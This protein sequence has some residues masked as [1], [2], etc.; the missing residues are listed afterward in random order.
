V[1]DFYL[2]ECDNDVPKDKIQEEGSLI[3]FINSPNSE[4]P[5][6][7][8]CYR[9]IRSKKEKYRKRVKQVQIKLTKIES[10]DSEN[11]I[12][13]LGCVNPGL[14]INV[15]EEEVPI[16]EKEE[17]SKI[18]VKKTKGFADNA[19][20]VRDRNRTDPSNIPLN[21]DFEEFNIYADSLYDSKKKTKLNGRKRKK[22]RASKSQHGLIDK[23]VPFEVLLEEEKQKR[24]SGLAL[25]Y[26]E[27]EVDPFNNDDFVVVHDYNTLTK[28]KDIE[29]NDHIKGTINQRTKESIQKIEVIKRRNQ[30]EKV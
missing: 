9:E 12:N 28:N 19:R 11:G 7:I 30:K 8:P 24:I 27:D 6:E 25:G 10:E 21:E 1:S 3:T 4:L 29:Y 23:N 2:E 15:L 20:M 17:A 26:E 13:L 18:K 14:Y 16:I 5:M 22:M